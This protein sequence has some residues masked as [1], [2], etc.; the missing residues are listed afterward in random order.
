MQRTLLESALRAGRHELARVLVS[1]RVYLRPCS[2]FNW[3]KRGALAE[4]RGDRAAAAAAR[5]EAARL[6][7]AGGSVGGAE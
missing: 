4:A 2:P 3:L 1:E 6:A 7:L 5:D